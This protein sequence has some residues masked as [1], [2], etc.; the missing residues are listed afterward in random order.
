MLTNSTNG[1]VDANMIFHYQQEGQ[2]LSCSY[3]G[4]DIVKGHLIGTVDGEGMIKM[5]YHQVNEAGQIKTGNCVST[6]E[7]LA[8][9]KLRLHEKWEWTSG[10]RSQGES[11][12]EEI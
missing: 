11:V 3:A 1:E 5:H 2:I 8:S 10:D 6:P 12:L 9:G 7:I 4:G